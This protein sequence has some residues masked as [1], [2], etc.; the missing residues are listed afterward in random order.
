MLGSMVSAMVTGLRRR[1]FTE[2]EELDKGANQEYNGKLP[3]EQ[4][5]GKRQSAGFSNEQMVGV[6]PDILRGLVARGSILSIC[7]ISVWVYH[8]S[9]E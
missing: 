4:S 5:L 9:I 6:K 7:L 1:C 3:D 2:D 8:C